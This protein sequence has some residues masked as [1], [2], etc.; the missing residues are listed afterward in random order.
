MSWISKAITE[1]SNFTYISYLHPDSIIMD[2]GE[3]VLSNL[4]KLR[5]IV[6][7]LDN[8]PFAFPY[9]DCVIIRYIEFC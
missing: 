6:C 1:Q 3:V 4:P 9:K 5:L 2:A 8:R 7:D